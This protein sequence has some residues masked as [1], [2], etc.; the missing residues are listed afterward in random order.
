VNS[1]IERQ[2]NLGDPE[3]D[4][5]VVKTSFALASKTSGSF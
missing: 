2:Q 1:D 5:H 3:G 4:I